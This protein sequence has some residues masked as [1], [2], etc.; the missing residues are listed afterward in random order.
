MKILALS[1]TIFF[2]NF[3]HNAY[4]KQWVYSWIFLLLTTTSLFVHSRIFERDT[5]FEN[6][7]IYLDKTVIASIFFY[8]GYLYWKSLENKMHFI[9]LISILIVIYLYIGGYFLQKYSFDPNQECA[10]LYHAALHVIGS[11]G[12]HSIIW[13]YSMNCFHT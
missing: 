12:H 11:L 4:H 8:G 1:S 3:L 5:E 10:D 6:Q 13:E 9:P 7:M 2:T